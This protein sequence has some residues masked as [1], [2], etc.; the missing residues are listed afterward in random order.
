M[1]DFAHA[2]TEAREGEAEPVL[3]IRTRQMKLSASQA[4]ALFPQ[5]ELA[6][7]VGGISSYCRSREPLTRLT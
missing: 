6:A 7:Q 5:N 1:L 2:M 4:K 3:L